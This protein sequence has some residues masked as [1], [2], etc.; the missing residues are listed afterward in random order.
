[1]EAAEAEFLK[2]NHEVIEVEI[3]TLLKRDRCHPRIK[4]RSTGW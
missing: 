2:L 3:P 1:M 4:P